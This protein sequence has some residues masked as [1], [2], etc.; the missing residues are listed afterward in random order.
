MNSVIETKPN[1]LIVDDEE[2]MTTILKSTLKNFDCNLFVA[3]GGEKALSIVNM[4]NPDLIL[5]DIVM[6]GLSGIEVCKKLKQDENLG[7]IPVIFLSSLNDT[8]QKVKAFDAGGVDFINKPIEPKELV[9]RVNLHIK[10]YKLQKRLHEEVEFSEQLRQI[11]ADKNE[12]LIRKNHALVKSFSN[13]DEL[14][15]AAT[16]YYTDEKL[17]YEWARLAREEQHLSILLIAVNK[18]S[19]Y[20]FSYGHSYGDECLIKVADAIRQV[21]KRPA[22]IMGRYQREIFMLILPNTKSEGA[23]HLAQLA[24]DAVDNLQIPHQ[25]F[26]Y[27]LNYVSLSIGLTTTIPAP[28]TTPENMVKITYEALKIALADKEKHIFYKPY[29]SNR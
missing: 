2:V 28:E 17:A 3:L 18:F 27:E 1:I 23:L 15:E 16:R 14:T 29:I 26:N 10:L 21:I 13:K 25:S 22:D 24:K 5:M 19:D 8:D 7:L 20:I 4:V 11:L 9:A 6:P 12:E